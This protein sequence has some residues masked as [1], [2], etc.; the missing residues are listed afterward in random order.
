[1][2][3]TLGIASKIQ[4]S[5]MASGKVKWFDN[6]KGFGFIAQDSGQDVFVHHTSIAGAGFKTLNEG[7]EVSFDV[8][9]SDKGLKAQNVQRVSPT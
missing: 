4:E 1:V 8:V 9:T 2:L 5:N 7:D 6:K 3:F